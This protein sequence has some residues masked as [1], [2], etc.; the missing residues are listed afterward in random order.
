V[1]RAYNV[2]QIDTVGRSGDIGQLIG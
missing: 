2:G 1:F